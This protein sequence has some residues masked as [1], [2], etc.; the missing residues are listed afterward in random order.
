[1]SYHDT[2]STNATQLK[3]CSEVKGRAVPQRKYLFCSRRIKTL[4]VFH[5]EHIDNDAVMNAGT[6]VLVALLFHVPWVTVMESEASKRRRTLF[7][8]SGMPV[9]TLGEKK[10][11]VLTHL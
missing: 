11:E 7:S 5:V 8:A 10:Y 2:L 3:P 4:I 6:A 1:M 9:A